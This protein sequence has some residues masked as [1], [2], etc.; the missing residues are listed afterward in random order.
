MGTGET[1]IGAKDDA[2]HER[3]PEEFPLPSHL[4][5]LSCALPNQFGTKYQGHFYPLGCSPP[6]RFE[7]WAFCEELANQFAEESLKSKAGRYAFMTAGQILAYRLP[8]LIATGW[9]SEVEVSRITRRAAEILGWPTP[10]SAL[11]PFT[12]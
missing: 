8:R 4:A 12:S 2:K 10:S 9:T 11:E 7:R 1:T 6:E 3:I 5:L